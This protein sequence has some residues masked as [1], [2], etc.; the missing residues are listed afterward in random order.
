MSLTPGNRTLGWLHRELVE[1]EQEGLLTAESANRLR[2]RYPIESTQPLQFGVILIAILGVGM[3]SAGVISLFAY[4]W[5]ELG[6][7]ARAVIAFLPLLIMQVLGVLALTRWKQSASVRESVGLGWIASIGACIALIAQTYQIAGDFSSFLLTWFILGLPVVYLMRS[8]VGFML[9]HIGLLVWLV[10]GAFPYGYTDSRYLFMLG[11]TLPYYFWIRSKPLAHPYQPLYLK[12]TLALL[13]PLQILLWLNDSLEYKWGLI[14]ALYFSA[15]FLWDQKK[16]SL[17]KRPFAFIGIL[18]VGLLMLLHSVE[19][20]NFGEVEDPF[21]GSWWWTFL[22]GG[23]GLFW[24]VGWLRSIGRKEAWLIASGSLPP[25]I[26][27]DYLSAQGIG[28]LTFTLYTLFVA[29]IVIVDGFWRARL[30]VLNYGFILMAMLV[31]WHFFHS[32]YGF[33]EKG[34]VFILLGVLFIGSNLYIPRLFKRKAS[35]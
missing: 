18:G 29:I 7:P 5:D 15:T 26:L 17:G 10:S 23:L 8:G 22:I 9:A 33:L 13:V 1:W 27:W 19:S 31:L 4:N 20:W 16:D 2:Q 34:I 14:L 24:L 11:A 3:I 21:W 12:W 25:L 30:L 6:R 28:E 32:S 35:V